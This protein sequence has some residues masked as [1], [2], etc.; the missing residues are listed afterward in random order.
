MLLDSSVLLLELSDDIADP[1]AFFIF[2]RETVVV[3]LA[4]GAVFGE[5]HKVPV[6][7]Q[8]ATPSVINP[9]ESNPLKNT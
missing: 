5:K 1:T 9:T 6:L 4:S 3:V 8:P 2:L 7:L